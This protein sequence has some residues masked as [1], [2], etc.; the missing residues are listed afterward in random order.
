MLVNQYTIPAL[1][2][3]LILG[4]LLGASVPSLNY[5]LY[6]KTAFFYL[7]AIG[8]HISFLAIRLIQFIFAE[9]DVSIE[10]SS[11]NLFIQ[12]FLFLAIVSIGLF[13]NNLRMRNPIQY[14]AKKILAI[15]LI[16][17]LIVMSSYVGLNY[18]KAQLVVISMVFAGLFYTLYEMFLYC[19]REKSI[20]SY[21]IILTQVALII[22]SFLGSYL[23]FKNGLSFGFITNVDGSLV[24]ALGL[25]RVL[26]ILIFAL[27]YFY[28]TILLV[29][30]YLSSTDKLG[31]ENE[32]LLTLTREKND[33][34]MTLSKSN[35]INISGALSAALAHELSQPL[36]SIQAN[37]DLLQLK[38]QNSQKI[39]LDLH[40][41][42]EKISQ[43][44]QRAGKILW[45]L[46]ALFTGDSQPTSVAINELVQSCCDM[47][48]SQ[49]DNPIDFSLNL[50]P[51][52]KT[53]AI[54]SEELRQVLL[55]I[56][57]NA[58]DAI[59]TSSVRDG[60]ISITTTKVDSRIKIKITDNG[61]GVPH[62]FVD[63][64]FELLKTSKKEG[65]GFGLWLSKYIVEKN[66]GYLYLRNE[67]GKGATF[68]IDL[69]VGSV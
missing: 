30:E 56:L 60:K 55:N 21:L 17:F 46:K 58:R 67:L 42:I 12:T 48:K 37:S 49:M 15:G 66:A 29:T 19:R 57:V 43:A 1:G 38:I 54:N 5:G 24:Q 47:L 3:I 65:M 18:I 64:I 53:N 2:L 4:I 25:I 20:N 50:F 51:E 62:E 9:P 31:L 32:R 36:A 34:L 45:S 39:S 35:K 52:I 27:I 22:T 6:R 10:K 61:G 26:Q 7:C 33:L 11:A 69:P 23:I 16:V 44:T 59:Q 40:E 68:V 63:H 14:Q 41:Q 8:C 28:I 13:F